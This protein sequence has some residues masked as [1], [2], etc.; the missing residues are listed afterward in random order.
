MQIKIFTLPVTADNTDLEE[1]NHF[2]RAQ[3]IIDI[4][5]ELVISDGIGQWTFCI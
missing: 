1:L 4:R 2:L 5:R 3:H